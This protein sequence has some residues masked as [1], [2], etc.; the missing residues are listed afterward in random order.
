MRKG[1]E[2]LQPDE[3][4]KNTLI[5][6]ENPRLTLLGWLLAWQLAFDQ[7]IDPADKVEPVKKSGFSVSFSRNIII[8]GKKETVRQAKIGQKKTVLQIDIF[9]LDTENIEA[10]VT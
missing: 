7:S 5:Q 6:I 3:Q 1:G 9:K 8:E 4:C 2:K 10:A